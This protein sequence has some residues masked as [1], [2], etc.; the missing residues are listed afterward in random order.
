MTYAAWHHKELTCLYFNV[1]TICCGAANAQRT[2]KDKEHLVF[3]KMSVKRELAENAY[4]LDVVVIHLTNYSGRP[5]FRPRRSG[6]QQSD[7]LLR[8]GHD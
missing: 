2:L 8:A 7:R 1:A 6:C 5:V 4:C 3:V